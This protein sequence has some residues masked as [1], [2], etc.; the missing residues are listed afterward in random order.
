LPKVF[1]AY[2]AFCIAILIQE[3]ERETKLASILTECQ[4]KV[5]NLKL[6]ISKSIP[7]LQETINIFKKCTGALIKSSEKLKASE[8]SRQL[9]LAEQINISLNLLIRAVAEFEIEDKASGRKS[10]VYFNFLKANR[11]TNRNCFNRVA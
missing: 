5:L 7:A 6:P 2:Q 10:Q 9:L 1:D 4:I 3:K 8:K 11:N